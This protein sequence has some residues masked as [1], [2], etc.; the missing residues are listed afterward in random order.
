MKPRLNEDWLAV[1]LGRF[2]FALMLTNQT[3]FHT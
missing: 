2:L 1:C 3:M